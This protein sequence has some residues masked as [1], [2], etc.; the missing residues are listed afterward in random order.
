MIMSHRKP[1]EERACCK[2]FINFNGLRKRWKMSGFSEAKHRLSLQ[3]GYF[4]N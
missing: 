2:Y 3:I 4:T 1:R